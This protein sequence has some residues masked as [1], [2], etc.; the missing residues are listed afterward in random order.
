[1]AVAVEKSARTP[2]EGIFTQV[3]VT[4]PPSVPGPL[5]LPPELL[6]LPPLLLVVALSL[7]VPLLLPPELPPLL[8]LPPPSGFEFTSL[9]EHA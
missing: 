6:P 7:P 1:L 5:L 2:L 9:V 4:P 3:A 8:E